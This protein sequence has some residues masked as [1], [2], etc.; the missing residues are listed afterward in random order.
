MEFR[1][2]GAVGV[3]DGDRQVTLGGMKQRSLLALLLLHRNEPVSTDRLVDELWG[4]RPPDTAHKTVQVYVSQLRKLLGDGRIETHGHSYVLR[5]GE[6]E[7]D[8]DR[9]EALVEG[10]R[11]EEP[12]RASASLRDALSLFRGEPLQDLAYEPWAQAEIAR[13]QEL[14]LAALEE[15]V[16]AELALGRHA[17]LVPELEARVRE[18]PLRERLR[19]QLMLAL[20]RSGRQ[21]DALESHRE[22]RRTLDE[23][24]GLE[25]GPELRELEQRILQQDPSLAAPAAPLAERSRK[26]RG[27]LLMVGGAA[28]LLAVAVGAAVV[29]LTGGSTASVMT[30]P[31]SVAVIDPRTNRVVAAIPV[32]NTPSDIAVGAGAVWTLSANEETLSKIDPVSGRVVRVVAVGAA[33]GV[34]VGD[35]SVWVT[36]GA[37]GQPLSVLRIDPD[38]GLVTR[39]IAVSPHGAEPLPASS[40]AVGSGGVWASGSGVL[41]RIDG[42]SGRVVERRAVSYDGPVALGADA[43]WVAE[44]LGRRPDAVGR[45]DARRQRPPVIIPL[46]FH[47]GDLAFGKGSVWVA[48]ASGDTVWRVDARTNTLAR[49]I[50]VGN[51]ATGVAYGQGSVWVAS[52][53]GTV[54]RIDPQSDRVT[55]TIDVG[56]TPFRI[57]VGEGR[58]WV[59]VD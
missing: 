42:R 4:E 38:S 50:S 16:D 48:N 19:A 57:A 2:L 36:S 59:T 43:V 21:A 30:Q 49:S 23:R 41:A 25:P 18:Q 40:I 46:P 9:F 22:G 27:L 1:I 10:A 6:G 37:L 8:L 29:D 47:P 56:G 35:G 58:V 3:V 5:V 15:R 11:E 45:F 28:L 17:Q 44:S 33:G 55:A 34:A 31:S 52:G 20:Y 24:L 13:L 54:S 12:R 51:L 32:G 26:R 39:A 53:D 14:R 7:L